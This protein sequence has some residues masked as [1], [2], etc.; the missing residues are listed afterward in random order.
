MV[1]LKRN[2]KVKIVLMVLTLI[3]FIPLNVK[4]FAALPDEVRDEISNAIVL[5]ENG[6]K[7]YVNG[8]ETSIGDKDSF[9]KPET[10]QGRVLVPVR[11]IAESLGGKV[12]WNSKEKAVI[13]S[14]KDKNI[15]FKIG[16]KKY[17]VNGKENSIDV[18]PKWG[19]H[20]YNTAYIPI[21]ALAQAF[22]KN[23]FYQNGLI[24]ISDNKSF[25]F[26]KPLYNKI[27]ASLA[28]PGLYVL[29]ADSG[30]EPELIDNTDLF[31][32]LKIEN[33]WIYI[34]DYDNVYKINTNTLQKIKVI[35]DK[36]DP[37]Y[38]VIVENGSIYYS[39][40]FDGNKIYK[41]NEK[42]SSRTRINDDDSEIVGIVDGYIY[43]YTE[44]D[45]YGEVYGKI[46]RIKTDGTDKKQLTNQDSIFEGVVDGWFYYDKVE[47]PVSYGVPG[48]LH[49][50]KLDESK[51]EQLADDRGQFQIIEEDKIY[52]KLGTVMG[53]V[54]R[55]ERDGKNL[56]V[57]A[58]DLIIEFY[59]V[60][61]WI[62][63]SRTDGSI[64][65]VTTDGKK[66]EKVIN[67]EGAYNFQIADNHIYY[68]SAAGLNV[69]DMD[70]KNLRDLL[71]GSS[72]LNSGDLYISDFNISGNKVFLRLGNR[73]QNKVNL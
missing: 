52:L 10:I 13:V 6:S 4:V 28:A 9:F 12:K 64:Y 65:K 24:I 66:E 27:L 62:Y 53:S 32:I 72:L 23:L 56:E 8:I 43:Y 44:R 42:D 49:R 57:I 47:H 55:M 34:N 1:I 61:D 37:G 54:G 39:N 69:V 21:R 14:T 3:F 51:D 73:T 59:K 33:E 26:E 19:H 30:K 36:I 50:L 31:E 38:K 15:K 40:A 35:S 48:K 60:N 20:D 25:N 11:F 45:A 29:D 18:A 68:E 63:F 58:D 46:W 41:V 70:G 16:D 2:F 5:Y 67:D 22:E 71:D 7:A 17:T